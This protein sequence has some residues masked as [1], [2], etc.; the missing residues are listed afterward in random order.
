MIED[1]DV[2]RDRQADANPGGPQCRA[3]LDDLEDAVMVALRAV[4]VDHRLAR[5]FLV[6]LD[7]AGHR[8]V[9]S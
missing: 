4:G 7:D 1:E 5:R 8:V 3:D 2:R 9:R 6:A